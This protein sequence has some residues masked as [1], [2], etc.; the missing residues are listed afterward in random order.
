MIA[1][2]A[3]ADVSQLY[4]SHGKILPPHQWPKWMTH[5]IEAIKPNE[6]GTGTIKL[7]SQ[8]NA[9]KLLLELSG[10]TRSVADSIDQMGRQHRPD[11]GGDSRRPRQ[12]SARGRY[13]LS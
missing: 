6:D 2:E 11:D 7:A 9:R 12:T 1:C 13:A 3:E 4:D 5:C 10:R 8:S